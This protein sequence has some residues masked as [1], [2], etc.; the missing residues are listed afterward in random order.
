MLS[1][2]FAKQFEKVKATKDFTDRLTK[3]DGVET[4]EICGDYDRK[5][6]R[7]LL[8]HTSGFLNQHLNTAFRLKQKIKL[9]IKETELVIV[10]PSDVGHD[11]YVAT[12]T[13]KKK[14]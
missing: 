9:I 10:Y 14:E 2:K 8:D 7:F 6:F 5:A 13:P 3:K 4:Y 11:R 12:L 1:K